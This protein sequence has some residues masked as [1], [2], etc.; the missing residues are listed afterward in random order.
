M[1]RNWPGSRERPGIVEDLGDISTG[2]VACLPNIDLLQCKMEHGFNNMNCGPDSVWRH[3]FWSDFRD[4]TDVLQDT[5]EWQG[6]VLSLIWTVEHRVLFQSP[7]HLLL[8][9]NAVNL[10]QQCRILSSLH[11]LTLWLYR[12]CCHSESVV[13]SF[14]LNPTVRHYLFLEFY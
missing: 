8:R 11:H 13:S 1:V 7:E 14:R 2:G 10:F 5:S 9:V 3:E 4:G 12:C 6:G